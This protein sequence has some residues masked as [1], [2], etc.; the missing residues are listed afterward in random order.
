M[1]YVRERF[2]VRNKVNITMAMK[3]NYLGLP[4]F[5]HAYVPSYLLIYKSSMVIEHND[6]WLLIIGKYL[7]HVLILCRKITHN[8][9]HSTISNSKNEEVTFSDIIFMQSLSIY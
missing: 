3:V 1:Y 5:L 2:V 9:M 8:I 7:M 6:Y 4:F